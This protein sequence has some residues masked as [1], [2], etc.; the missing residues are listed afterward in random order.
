MID[1][2]QDNN[3]LQ[4]DILFL[5]AE[6][7]DT[8]NKGIP[9]S[10]DLSAGKLFFVGDEK[11]SIYLFRGADVSVFR[12]LKEEIKSADLP[13][14]TNFRS[15][16]HLIN[17]FNAIF[18]LVFA[19]SSAV[20]AESAITRAA[21]SQSLPLYEAGYTPLEA[22]NINKEKSSLCNLS[23]CILNKKSEIK[24]E[25]TPL[26]S[27]ESEAKFVA[28]K[29]KLLIK[30]K[31]QPHE[32]AVLFRTR[33]SQYL[34]EKHLR[35]L[36]IPYSCEDI[37]DL[38]FGGPVN[39]ILSVLRIVSHPMDKAAYAEMLRSPF[40]GLTISGTAE[41]LSVFSDETENFQPFSDRALAHLEDFD[42]EKFLYG[43]R[44][45]RKICEKAKK[46]NISS[47]VSE[48]WYNEG[49]RYETEWNPQTSVYRELF[50]YLYH[51]GTKADREN[52]GL[53]YFTDSMI[54][55]RNSGGKLA[56]I[57]IPLERPG[58]VHLMTIHKSKGLE[59]PVVFLCGCGKRSQTDTSEIVFLSDTNGIVFS[60]PPPSECRRISEKRN[61][62]FWEQSSEEIKRKR[63]AELRRLLYVGMTRAG[64]DLYITGSLEIKNPDETENFSLLLKKFIEDK[65]KN[66]AN[67]IEGDLIINN[68]T[69]FGLLL[70][71]IAG[72]IPNDGLGTGSFFRLEEIPRLS[73]EYIKEEESKN[74]KVRNSQKALDDF[75]QNAELY[76]KKAEII[77]T[78]VLHDNHITAVSLKENIADNGDENLSATSKFVN[79]GFSGKTC[80][81]IF[82]NVDATLLRFSQNTDETS[83]KLNSGSFGTIAHICVEAQLN[84]TE[85]VIPSNIS[86]LLS[87]PEMTDLLE[88]GKELAKRFVLSPLGKIA[89]TAKLRESE[90]SFRSLL[91]NRKGKEIFING[92]VDLFFEDKETI[93]IVDFKTDSSE[94]PGEHTAQMSCY[95][96][97]ICALFAVPLKKQCRIWLY[98]LR[99]GHAVEMTE[100]A[101]H[102]NLENRAFL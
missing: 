101:K 29:I 90:F 42:R 36:G 86:G 53:S 100:K 23:L 99:T 28:E 57:E 37:N 78:P 55:I 64:K 56:D 77:K 6:R 24:T 87:P 45:Y 8:V 93:H 10:E 89:E 98:Y 13:L 91:K 85:A 54:N 69:L 76:Y 67:Y 14:K 21:N 84:N 34:F 2:F 82:K 26:S 43:Q 52:Q 71:A 27:D 63:T 38:F 40:A 80:D 83:E 96:H 7:P 18:P 30:E 41:C 92:T 5:L 81:D 95:Y 32:I 62:F 1:E 75:L 9:P 20:S 31:Y 70:P 17:A 19:G 60:A 39:D 51:L 65:C 58:A 97:A 74:T 35:T 3:E 94:K 49:Y 22:G 59:F 50:D 11:Q 16:A 47:L 66:T 46:E 88:A 12:K 68:D 44:I 79:L 73:E 102:F 15:S 48:L 25:E 33:S 61:N 72:H 4:K